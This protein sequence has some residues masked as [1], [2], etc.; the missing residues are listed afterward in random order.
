[1]KN[2]ENFK[3]VKSLRFCN[4]L[5]IKAHY[6]GKQVDPEWHDFMA[7]QMKIFVRPLFERSFQVRNFTF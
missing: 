6:S 4:Q 2:R 3:N 5:H 1:M 7:V